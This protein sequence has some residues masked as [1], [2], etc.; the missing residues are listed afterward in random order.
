MNS[1]PKDEPPPLPLAVSSGAHTPQNPLPPPLPILQPVSTPPIPK[2]PLGWPLSLT[3]IVLGALVTILLVR[4][5]L[6]TLSAETAPFLIGQLIGMLVVWPGLIWG[7]FCIGRAFRTARTGAII[8]IV[9]WSL[10]LLGLLGKHA[11]A[12]ASKAGSLYNPNH[13]SYNGTFDFNNNNGNHLPAIPSYYPRSATTS[14]PVVDGR[15]TVAEGEVPADFLEGSDERFIKQVT[16][17]GE[18]KY[19]AVVAGYREACLHSPENAQLAVERVK[20]IEHFAF[21]E[22]EAF[23]TSEDDLREAEAFFK[24]HFAHA[25]EYILHLLRNPFDPRFDAV[26][27]G[28]GE[29]FSNWEPKQVGQYYLLR[30]RAAE[31]KKQPAQAAKFAA[32]SIALDPTAQAKLLLA[33]ELH[34]D[35]RDAEARSVLERFDPV[36]ASTYE[37][38]QRM[39]LLFQIHDYPEALKAYRLLRSAHSTSVVDDITAT[40]LAE[41]G[42]VDDARVI[43]AKPS[44]NQY[45]K[46]PGLRRRFEFELKHG[47][48][49]EASRAYE[50][51]RDLGVKQDPLAYGR[52]RLFRAHPLAAWSLGDVGSVI[53]LGLFLAFAFALP[54]LFFAP[55]HY[56]SLLRRREPAS[57]GVARVQGGGWSLRTTCLV[58][59]IL[60]LS[61]TLAFWYYAPEELRRIV[62]STPKTGGESGGVLHVMTSYWIC[63]AVVVAWLLLRRRSLRILGVGTWSWGKSIGFA[64]LAFI[65]LRIGLGIYLQ[66][67]PGAS[68][69][70]PATSF[71]QMPAVLALMREM[72]AAWGPWPTIAV[73]ALF[74]PVIEEFAFRGMLL[75]A[76]NRHISF[77]AANLL[78]AVL[79]ASLHGMLG[80]LPFYIVF[81]MISGEFA[82]RSGGLFPSILMHVLNNLAACLALIGVFH[83]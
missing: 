19:H 76:L 45:D 52:L 40:Y 34:A 8:A 41:A 33:R 25:P 81:A 30:A 49:D 29:D 31:H 17:V 37:Q 20:F 4:E 12:T 53:V 36:T 32:S 78:Q 67:F 69:A 82:R 68:G 5:R 47:S 44:L 60:L 9:L 74:V 23:A 13:L 11:P 26:V 61:Q 51:L 14:I 56:W 66:I 38:K 50:A 10:A 7:L 3:L 1:D 22:E 6:P 75:P 80:L 83:K 57:V 59:G 79:F 71:A 70:A 18:D 42:D 39:T 54:F 43:F 63:T 21:S 64:F 2:K 15:P 73:A 65:G 48:G 62:T 28:F 55:V 58:W 24:A 46:A 16:K 72:L 35:N 77:C 27:A